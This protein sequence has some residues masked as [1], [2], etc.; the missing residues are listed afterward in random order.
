MTSIPRG[1]LSHVPRWWW[2]W[3]MNSGP[4]R[5]VSFIWLIYSSSSANLV[6]KLHTWDCAKNAPNTDSPHSLEKGLASASDDHVLVDTENSIA[7]HHSRGLTNATLTHI[8]RY[9][10]VV[11]PCLAWVLIIFNF[12]IW[13][14][15]K[16]H[17]HQ[18]STTATIS[19]ANAAAGIDRA[20]NRNRSNRPSSWDLH[21]PRDWSWRT[22]RSSEGVPLF[23][24]KFRN[25]TRDL[26]LGSEASPFQA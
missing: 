8:S 23:G 22:E 13:S 24:F 9:W 14:N 4:T 12:Q 17:L 1:A 25:G 6:V 3:P 5:T 11:L 15:K 20:R 16:R 21:W 19:L 18:A 7:L 2:W 10:G 26:P